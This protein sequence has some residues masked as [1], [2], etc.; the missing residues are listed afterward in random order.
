MPYAAVL[1]KD[2]RVGGRK[3]DAPRRVFYLFRVGRLPRAP[4]ARFTDREDAL[5]VARQL[6]RQGWRV[7]V[8]S[9]LEGRDAP[10]RGPWRH[11]YRSSRPRRDSDCRSDA[12]ER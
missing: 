4:F 7:A 1:G 5:S 12:P 3:T 9:R 2:V 8:L 6:E 10:E 11:E